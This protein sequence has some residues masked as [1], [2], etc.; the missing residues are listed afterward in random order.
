[1]P[2]LL[3]RRLKYRCWFLLLVGFCLTAH[4]CTAARVVKPPPTTPGPII[5]GIPYLYLD[6]WARQHGMECLWDGKNP[7]IKLRARWGNASLSL[8]SRNASINGINLWLSYGIRIQ[9]NRPIIAQRDLRNVIEA[10]LFPRKP[11]PPRPIRTIAIDPG[12]GGKDPGFML[13]ARAEKTYNLLLAQ[14]VREL[15]LAAGFKVVFTRYDDRFVEL[16]DRPQLARRAG[17]DLLVSLHHNCAVNNTEAKGVETYCA[18]PLGTA[19]TNGGGPR[20][21][22]EPS[23]KFDDQNILLAYEIHKSLVR[24]L[25]MNDRGVRRAGFEVLRKAPMPGVLIEA[26]FM[27]N[28]DD[29][30]KVFDHKSR[31]QLARAIVDGI[32]SYK[33]TMERGLAP[34]Q[35]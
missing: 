31:Q 4:L 15:L 34:N 35:K 33:R 29:A 1:M 10:L 25:E 19:S 20:E 18:T 32:L 9:N 30:K 28:L 24:S 21:K 23:N 11:N 12:H 3:L 17:A 2:V 5:N 6:S 7:E 27:S 16:E 13:G 8:D 22:A 26:G 14:E